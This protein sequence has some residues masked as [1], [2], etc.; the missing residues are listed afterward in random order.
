MVGITSV[1][2]GAGAGVAMTVPVAGGGRVGW[3]GGTL[4]SPAV[5][6]MVGGVPE[7]SSCGSVGVGPGVGVSV[8]VAVGVLVDVLV[9]V[10]VGASVMTGGT[11][12]SPGA[13]VPGSAGVCVIDGV[14]GVAPG[15]PVSVLPG[16]GV[17]PGVGRLVPGVGRLVP[18]SA[19]GM[20]VG[21][22]LPVPS[23]G[24]VA[25]GGASPRTPSPGAWT[26]G[27]KTDAP[28]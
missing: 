13:G 10:L 26:S 22:G 16:V 12:V 9:D 4:V 14:G 24:G 1:A 20:D 5:A 3:P 8:S 25:G 6:T 23:E 19:V 11:G 18:P 21:D 28:P 27:R 7:G 15:A 17:V 2:E